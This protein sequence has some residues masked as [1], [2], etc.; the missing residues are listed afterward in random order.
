MTVA[1]L[2]AVFMFLFASFSNPASAVPLTYKLVASITQIGVTSAGSTMVY[3]SYDFHGTQF[4]LDEALHGKVTYGP[5]STVNDMNG[6]DDSILIYTAALQSIDLSIPSAQFSV[7]GPAVDSDVILVANNSHQTDLLWFQQAGPNGT[8]VRVYYE[9]QSAEA[10]NDFSLPLP[11]DAPRFTYG[12]AEFSMVDLTS[13]DRLFISARITKTDFGM[14][15]PE[16]SALSLFGIGLMTLLGSAKWM[17]IGSC[18][19][20]R[21]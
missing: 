4:S 20:C 1:R 7:G 15:V 6:T 9:D 14:A 2:A 10:L 21:I 19:R 18:S 8:S 3:S 11:F 12:F 13:G 17:K 5:G 16:P